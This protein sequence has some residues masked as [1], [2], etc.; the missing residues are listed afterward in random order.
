MVREILH[1]VDFIEEEEYLTEDY[2]MPIRAYDAPV[3]I[4]TPDEGEI[5]TFGWHE[6]DGEEPDIVDMEDTYHSDG[7]VDYVRSEAY[8]VLSIDY[9]YHHNYQRGSDN[10]VAID[11]IEI[12]TKVIVEKE[13]TPA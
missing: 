2:P 7:P 1:T 10:K 8:R 13:A 3:P 5:L 9:H 12:G 6:I 11:R 4:P